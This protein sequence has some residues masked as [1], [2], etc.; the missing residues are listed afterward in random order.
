M[1]LPYRRY[2]AEDWYTLPQVAADFRVD[3]DTVL[4]WRLGSRMVG[5]KQG[6]TPL[7]SLKCAGTHLFRGDWIIQFWSQ[8]DEDDN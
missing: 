6:W 1:D 7:H 3:E 4:K 5:D 8:Q 2:T